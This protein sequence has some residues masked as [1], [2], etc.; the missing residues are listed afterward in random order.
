MQKR[1]FAPVAMPPA[2]VTWNEN[3]SSPGVASP[4]VPSSKKGCETA[5]KIAVRSHRT[6]TPVLS[7]CEPGTT[8]TVSSVDSPAEIDAGTA[9]PTPL[10]GRPAL[11]RGSGAPTVKS[12]EL[13]LVS[14][15]P[16]PFRRAAVVL[17]RPGVGLVSA[18]LALP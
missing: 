8:D 16:S 15:A 14:I 4:F 5:P 13:S 12:A 10:G 11:L 1:L 2:T 18:Q 3:T 7:G 9:A 6:F 17:P